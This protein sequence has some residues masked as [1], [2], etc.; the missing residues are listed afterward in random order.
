M[1][2]DTSLRSL[3]SCHVPV[4]PGVEHGAEAADEAEEEGKQDDG[5]QGLTEV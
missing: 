3:L 5:E 2:H 1:R 4:D